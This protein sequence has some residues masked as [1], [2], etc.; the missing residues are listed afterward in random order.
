M[1]S[2]FYLFWNFNPSCLEPTTP[3]KF[4]TPPLPPPLVFK[5]NLS[6]TRVCASSAAS[7][8]FSQDPPAKRC[9][10]R[11]KCFLLSG[12]TC[13]PLWLW[14]RLAVGGWGGGETSAQI[15]SWLFVDSV[16]VFWL[17]FFSLVSLQGEKVEQKTR[18]KENGGGSCEIANM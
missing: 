15:Y 18:R 14:L 17:F 2:F 4:P 3:E 16:V 6:L 10:G 12:S 5:D 8:W 9:E 11:S 1:H 7:I 13:V